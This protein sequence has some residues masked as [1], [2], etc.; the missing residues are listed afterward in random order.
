VITEDAVDVKKPD[1]QGIRPSLCVWE[2]YHHDGGGVLKTEKG[3]S[4]G[5]KRRKKAVRFGSSSGGQEVKGKK[6]HLKREFWGGGIGGQKHVGK[7]L[8]RSWGQGGVQ[9]RLRVH[10]RIVLGF[11]VPIV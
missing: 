10:R 5:E 11:S 8:Q 6:H 9:L 1:P 4:V 3:G 2:G 7:E